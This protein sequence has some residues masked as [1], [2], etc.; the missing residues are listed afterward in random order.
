MVNITC[1]NAAMDLYNE[2][3]EP[4]PN[5]SLLQGIALISTH[6][7][8]KHIDD[9][10]VFMFQGNSRLIYLMLSATPKRDSKHARLLW[11]TILLICNA[12]DFHVR[13]TFRSFLQLPRHR[14]RVSMLLR[15]VMLGCNWK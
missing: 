15:S 13:K 12:V 6:F 3:Q 5:T 8:F 4:L 9:N 1:K 7:A 14:S 10:V 11:H 2:E